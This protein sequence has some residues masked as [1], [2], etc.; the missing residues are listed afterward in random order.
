[1]QGAEAA[2]WGAANVAVAGTGYGVAGA[3]D[4][5]IDAGPFGPPDEALMPTDLQPLGARIAG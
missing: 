1:M 4:G 5:L 2:A 3:G